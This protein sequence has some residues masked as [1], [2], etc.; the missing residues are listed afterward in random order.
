[1]KAV[2]EVGWARA[3]RFA[4]LTLAMIPYRCA[5]LPP[6]R[7][8]WLRLLGARIGA[9]VVLHHVGF[10]NL[11]RRGLGGLSVGDE[12]YTLRAGDRLM[13]PKGMVHT[14]YTGVEGCLYFIG[15]KA[16]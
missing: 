4:W 14:A 3:A 7:I 1:L 6:V 9:R 15:Q 8:A 13:L 11:Y 12:C 2:Q 5:L 16:G 10:F